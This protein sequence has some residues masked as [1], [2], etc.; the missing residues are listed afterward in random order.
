MNMMLIDVNKWFAVLMTKDPVATVNNNKNIMI[1]CQ[2]SK[3]KRIWVH[4]LIC[5]MMSEVVNKW[6]GSPYDHWPCGRY[7]SLSLSD[8]LPPLPGFYRNSCMA[9]QKKV[10]T[11]SW[12]YSWGVNQSTVSMT[13]PSKTTSVKQSEFSK[14]FRNEEF[15]NREG[16]QRPFFGMPGVP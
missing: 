15:Q 13:L 6:Y 4:C 7:K 16:G 11:C 10:D 3:R 2:K 8:C 9:T 14:L 1:C 12:N 5:V